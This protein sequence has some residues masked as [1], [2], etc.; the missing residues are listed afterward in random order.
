[1]KNFPNKIKILSDDTIL[2][3][4]EEILDKGKKLPVRIANYKYIQAK[5]LLGNI[6]ILQLPQIINLLADSRLEIIE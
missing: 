5:A 1:M 6:V 3:F 4:E 2:I